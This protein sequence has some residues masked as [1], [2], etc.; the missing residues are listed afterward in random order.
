MNGELNFPGRSSAKAD[1]RRDLCHTK[2]LIPSGE[3]LI[4]ESCFP[5]KKQSPDVFTAL[6]L[7]V[8]GAAPSSSVQKGSDHPG[9]SLLLFDAPSVNRFFFLM[10]HCCLPAG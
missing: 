9:R 1:V 4:S 2:V 7:M 6:G 5:A 10:P 3:S 8:R